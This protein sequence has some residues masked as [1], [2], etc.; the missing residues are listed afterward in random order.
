MASHGARE[1]WVKSGAT[2]K[3]YEFHVADV[4]TPILSVSLCD[5]GTEVHN[6]EQHHE[7]RCLPLQVTDSNEKGQQLGP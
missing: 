3:R 5:S 6:D 4:T 7:R 2:T 1:L